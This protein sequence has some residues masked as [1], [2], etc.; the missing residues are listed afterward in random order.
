[1]DANV[2]KMPGMADSPAPKSECRQAGM[3]D[4]WAVPGVCIFLAAITLAVFWRTFHYGFVFF[5]DDIYVYDN[6]VVCGG[7]T[8]KGIATV[9]THVECNFYHPL[10]MISLMLNYQLNGLQPGAYHLTNVLLHIVSAIL[11]F[12]ILRRMTGFTWRSAFVAAVFAIH[13]LRVESVAWVAE[14]KD[15]LSG[16]FFMLTL[17]AY[18]SYV[19]APR[20]TLRYLVVVIL[21]ALGLLCKP[22]IVTLPFVMLLLDYWPLQRFGN[23]T[24][25]SVFV[26]LVAEKIPLFVLSAAASVIAPI[27]EGKTMMISLAGVSLLA[28]MSHPIT[29][30]VIYLKQLFYPAGLALFYPLSFKDFSIWKLVAALALLVAISAV[31]LA[32]WRKRPYLLVGWLWFVGMLVP[33][34][35]IMQVGGFAHADRFTYLPTIGLCIAL[36]WAVADLCAGWRHRSALLG[37]CAMIMLVVLMICARIQAFYWQDSESLWTRTLACTSDNTVAHNNLG[38]ALAKKGEIDRAIIQFQEAIRLVPDYAQAHNNLGGALDRKNRF[39]EAIQQFQEAI[40]LEPD[41]ASAYY[42]LGGVLVKQD[43]LD[44]AIRQFQEAIRLKPDLAEARSDLGAALDK[45]GLVD[46]AINQFREAIRLKPDFAEARNN[47]GGDLARNGQLDEAINQF[48]E[49]IRLKPDFAEAHNNLGDALARRGRLDEAINQFQEAIRL[50]PDFASA[51]YNLG[52][53]LAAKGRL[54]EAVHQFQEAIRL[55]P[56]FAEAHSNLG[57]VL[58]SKGRLDEAI[59]QYQEAIR[60]KPDYAEARNN[61]GTAFESKGQID[62]AISQ[63]QEAIRLNPNYAQARNNLARVLGMKNAP[64]GH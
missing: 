40:R 28:R 39:D 35:G 54:D 61:L 50:K 1:M 38:A 53:A 24:A 17:W 26:R 5:D 19:Q 9:F 6:P 57:T 64:A 8:L 58:E 41:F 37:G 25:F 59:N 56:D 27:A 48:Q 51:C 10:T 18:V 36:T 31:A 33:M 11:L 20:S 2:N 32:A 14:R 52:N 13:P 12:L 46:E 30:Y 43:R 15:V 34:I 55:K 47:F 44:A 49:A 16:L 63:Y 22:S 3:N 23:G 21:F 60:L 45:K 42:N 29:T 7:L 4:R 62:E